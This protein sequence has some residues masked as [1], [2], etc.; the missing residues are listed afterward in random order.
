MINLAIAYHEN[1]PNSER[2]ARLHEART[3]YERAY[4]LSVSTAERADRPTPIVRFWEIRAPEDA[5]YNKALEETYRAVLK[6]RLNQVRIHPEVHLTHAQAAD[7]C[8]DLAGLLDFLHRPDEADT[9]FG[10]AQ[11]IMD[12]LTARYRKAP[13]YHSGRGAILGARARALKS[14]GD[15]RTARQLLEQAIKSGWTAVRMRPQC[16]EYLG[17]LQGHL[18][19][20][21]EVRALEGNY[22]AAARLLMDSTEVFPNRWE[23][24]YKSAATL[25]VW[26]PWI[27]KD[28]RLPEKEFGTL[29]DLFERRAVQLLREAVRRGLRNVDGVKKDSTLDSLRSRD[30]FKEFLAELE[31]AASPKGNAA[32]VPAPAEKP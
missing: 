29:K 16:S 25:A 13:G 1:R 19:D 20:L 2:M 24:C 5:T 10:Q 18:V 26:V 7:C 23:D 14:R 22:A 31:K 27:Q 17:Y 11:K 8:K 32:K 21:S 9:L 4:V 3:C 15:L 6:Y 30:D 28:A 12:D